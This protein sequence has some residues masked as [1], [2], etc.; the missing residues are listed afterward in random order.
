MLDVM[1]SALEP[2]IQKVAVTAADQLRR[3]GL[4]QG[5]RRLLTKLLKH[6]FGLTEEALARLTRTHLDGAT[7]EQ[8]DAW[9]TRLL[10]AKSVD[11]VFAG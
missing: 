1:R 4:L 8:L 6:R 10:D 3:E 5:V 7:P 9:G 2:Q 11:E